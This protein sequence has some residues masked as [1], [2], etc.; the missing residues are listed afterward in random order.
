LKIQDKRV[1]HL[2]PSADFE[3]PPRAATRLRRTRYVFEKVMN[4]PPLGMSQDRHSA[5]RTYIRAICMGTP[6]VFT[7]H[8]VLAALI[9]I[10]TCDPQNK[11]FRSRKG[12]RKRRSSLHLNVSQ[13]VSYRGTPGCVSF[14]Q[15]DSQSV[16]LSTL[17][18]DFKHESESIIFP[19]PRSLHFRNQFELRSALELNSKC[20]RRV[21]NI[22][23]AHLSSPVQ[24]CFIARTMFLNKQTYQQ[25]QL[26]A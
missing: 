2:L 18:C 21:D 14:G 24:G 19:H 25:T 6:Y 13:L 17:P 23:N 4:S 10:T 9:F 3:L 22:W 1:E 11:M 8:I 15:I 12:K 7:S 26:S 16:P 5:L 20:L